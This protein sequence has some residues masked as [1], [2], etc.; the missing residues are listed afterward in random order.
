MS[1]HQMKILSPE[2]SLPSSP[3]NQ[4]ANAR[5]SVSAMS[6]Q[7]FDANLKSALPL[8]SLI[9][10]D[11]DGVLNASRTTDTSVDLSCHWPR[12]EP[13]VLPW[14]SRRRQQSP[15]HVFKDCL[16]SAPRMPKHALLILV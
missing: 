5:P 3:T 9:F 1:G 16:N 8:N 7:Q 2:S 4:S 12:K 11:V 10:L 13:K 6:Q 15:E 14:I